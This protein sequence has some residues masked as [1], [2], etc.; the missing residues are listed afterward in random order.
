MYLFLLTRHDQKGSLRDNYE[1]TDKQ[2]VCSE[3]LLS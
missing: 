2:I 3:K 1:L